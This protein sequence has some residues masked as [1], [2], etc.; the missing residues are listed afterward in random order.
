MDELKTATEEMMTNFNKITF[1][2]GHYYYFM[3]PKIFYNGEEFV[4]PFQR[5][6]V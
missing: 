3:M 5:R 2:N 6:R 1:R 4:I